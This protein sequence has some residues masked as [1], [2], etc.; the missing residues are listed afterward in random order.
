LHLWIAFLELAQTLKKKKPKG[1]SKDGIDHQHL[2]NQ[3]E[4]NHVP[5]PHFF[6]QPPNQELINVFVSTSIPKGVP[7][8]MDTSPSSHH[9]LLHRAHH[10]DLSCLCAFS[11]LGLFPSLN[12]GQML[13]EIPPKTESHSSHCLRHL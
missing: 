12:L 4:V 5:I 1:G 3:R 10:G 7:K 6:P 2:A 9:L 11:I 13:Q 8:S